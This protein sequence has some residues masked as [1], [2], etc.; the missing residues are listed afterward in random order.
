MLGHSGGGREAIPLYELFDA[1]TR[2]VTNGGADEHR[3]L[4]EIAARRLVLVVFAVQQQQC[5]GSVLQ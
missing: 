2:V 4:Q 3:W 1:L 5:V